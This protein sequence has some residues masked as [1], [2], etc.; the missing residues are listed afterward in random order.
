[1]TTF[2]VLL[3]LLMLVT[4]AKRAVLPSVVGIVLV[5]GKLIT[6]ANVFIEIKYRT[7]QA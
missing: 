6:S 5:F 4:P 7:Q 3:L 2:A 1:M